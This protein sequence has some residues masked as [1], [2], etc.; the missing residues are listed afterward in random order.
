MGKLAAIFG[1]LR[2]GASVANPAAWKRGQVTATALGGFF[3]ALVQL[4]KQFGYDLPLDTDTA[5]AVAGGI[6]AAVNWALTIATSKTIGVPGM[7]PAG[8]PATGV[9]H[10]PEPAQEPA[11]VSR[12][13]DATR[14]QAEEYLRAGG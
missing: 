6:V 10:S 8:E 1:V 3:I 2:K 4:L 9:V 14:R 11:P 12:F 5:T 13:D 7:V